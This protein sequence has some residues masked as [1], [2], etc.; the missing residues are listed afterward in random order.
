LLTVL[1]LS[2]RNAFADQYGEEEYNTKFKIVKEVRIA[3]DTEWK[4]KVTDVRKDDVVE[5][6]IRI[7]NY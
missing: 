4:D 2:T 7:K 3:G 1:T 5:F 6:R